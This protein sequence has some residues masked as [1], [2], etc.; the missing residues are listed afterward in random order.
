M[1][2]MNRSEFL[3]SLGLKGSA[4][5]AFY[6]MGELVGCTQ[7]ETYPKPSQNVNF[8]IDLNDNKYA[9]LKNSGGYV[10]EQGILIA[11]TKAGTYI[12]LSQYCTHQGTTVVYVNNSD[13]LY[14]S[15][16]GARFAKSGAVTKGPASASLKQYTV[17]QNGNT[18]TIKS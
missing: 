4:L 7:S 17:T 2:T 13:D 16:H 18:L 14:C 10:Y 11:N 9:A 5:L 15:N 6:C 3:K 8:T 12:A 1:E